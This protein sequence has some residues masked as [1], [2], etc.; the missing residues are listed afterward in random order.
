MEIYELLLKPRLYIHYFIKDKIQYIQV[1]M[2]NAPDQS[3]IYF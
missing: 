3:Y 1:I 2:N